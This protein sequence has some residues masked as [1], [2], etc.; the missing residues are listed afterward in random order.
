M[1]SNATA[2]PLNKF[3]SLAAGVLACTASAAEVITLTHRISGILSTATGSTNTG[4]C[5]HKITPYLR[6]IITAASFAPLIV[7]PINTNQSVATF[8]FKSAAAGI[9][10][11]V[12]AT[13]DFFCEHLPKMNR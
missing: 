7:G 12:A 1:A 5:P 11:P 4:L 6:S 2:T 8:E 3:T 13:Y 10:G 9:L